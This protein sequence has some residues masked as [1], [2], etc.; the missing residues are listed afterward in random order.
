MQL[1]L[2]S[3]APAPGYY[4]YRS[5][6]PLGHI[7]DNETQL[8][9]LLGAGLSEPPSQHPMHLAKELAVRRSTTT[10]WW[11]QMLTL[12]SFRTY[13]NYTSLAWLGSRIMDKLIFSLI[14]L[15][16]YLGV[17]NNFNIDSMVN[18]SASLFMWTTLPASG[19]AAYM[20]SIVQ[21]QL[22]VDRITVFL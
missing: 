5:T 16:L 15:T 6:T 3:H 11:S 17:G 9:A 20:P 21:G 22:A 1:R 4:Y 14:I 8:E 2:S 10:P 7:Q 19:A 13:S 12:F 18:I